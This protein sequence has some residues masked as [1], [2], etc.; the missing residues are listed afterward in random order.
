MKALTPTQAAYVA[1][2]LDGDGSIFVRLKPNAAYKYGFQ[3]APYIVFFQSEKE[4][5]FL[6]RLQEMIGVG[7]VRLRKDGI[8]ELTVGSVNALRD[9]IRQLEPYLILKKQQ[10][11]LLVLIL[12][13]KEQVK[14]KHD[15]MELAQ[16]VDQY[17]SLNYSKKRTITL[18]RV[19][20]D[21]LK[22]DNP[23]ETCSLAE[24]SRESG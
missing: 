21:F 11:R 7:Y 1:G 23:V 2:F 24:R 5:A 8:A 10:A 17:K 18:E 6:K 9:L 3:I 12:E 13:R 16:L 22:S 14:S 19:V 20:Q 4:I 15:F